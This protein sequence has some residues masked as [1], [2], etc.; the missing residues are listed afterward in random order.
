MLDRNRKCPGGAATTRSPAAFSLAGSHA[1]FLPKRFQNVVSILFRSVDQ[2]SP[3]A[4]AVFWLFHLAR[5]VVSQKRIQKMKTREYGLDLW[6]YAT[7]RTRLWAT[8]NC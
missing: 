1:P 7:R 6:R 5:P 2:C 8:S 4:P 3:D